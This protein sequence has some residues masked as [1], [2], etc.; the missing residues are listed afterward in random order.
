MAQSIRLCTWNVQLGLH[1]ET[2]LHT[3]QSLVDFTGVDLFALQEASIH[4]GRTDASAIAAALGPSYESYQVTAHTFGQTAQANALVWNRTRVCV[5]KRDVVVL[6]R[7][8]EGMLPRAERAILCVLPEQNRI[9]V[10]LE[11]QIGD[12]SLR[13]YV[14]HLDVLGAAHKRRQFYRILEDARARQ[15]DTRLTVVAG[16]LNTIRI[17]PLPSWSDLAARRNGFADLTS[18][19]RWTHQIRLIRLRQKLDAIFVRYPEPLRSHAWSVD[20]PGS[21]HIPVFA[22][23]ILP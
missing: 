21:D 11:G 9:S 2:I 18:G 4:A 19:I 3:V 1:L 22:E 7:A 17:R 13:V 5:S 12:E 23:I 8:R 15:P 10:V 16:D 14:A 20:T 6:P